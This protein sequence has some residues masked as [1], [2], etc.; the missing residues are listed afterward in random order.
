LV[1]HIARAAAST[2]VNPFFYQ[3][4]LQ[5]EKKPDIQWKKLT[6]LLLVENTKRNTQC[7]Y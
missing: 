1:H 6:G 3:D 5:L 2:D 7:A 4:I